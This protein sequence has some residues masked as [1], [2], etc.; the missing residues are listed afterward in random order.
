MTMILKNDHKSSP[1]SV[2]DKRSSFDDLQLTTL[3]CGLL[4]IVWS[5]SIFQRQEIWLKNDIFLFFSFKML[6]RMPS[7]SLNSLIGSGCRHNKRCDKKDYVQTTYISCIVNINVPP[8][9]QKWFE[10]E[11]NPSQ[12]PLP[13]ITLFRRALTLT[14]RNNSYQGFFRTFSEN[15]LQYN[16]PKM[17]GEGGGR[18]PLGIFP[19]INL[20]SV[21]RPFVDNALN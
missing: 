19:K 3:H 6:K 8:Q 21:A 13:F 7:F 18:R 5:E 16:F 17:M 9:N 4:F 14:V 12:S 20:I 2:L 15:N 1:S 11:N 10:T